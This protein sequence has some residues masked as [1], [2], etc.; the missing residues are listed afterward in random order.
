MEIFNFKKLP[1]NKGVNKQNKTKSLNLGSKV[2]RK[3]HK[4]FVIFVT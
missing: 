2:S 4:T 1:L 3:I